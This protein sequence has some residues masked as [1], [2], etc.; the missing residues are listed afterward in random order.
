[1]IVTSISQLPD[2]L[3]GHITLDTE[4]KDPELKNIGPGWAF[5]D[6]G[7]ISGVSIVADN[8]EGYI[9]VHQARGGN[10]EEKSQ[11][12]KWLEHQL[13]NESQ[14]KIFANNQYDQGWLRRQGI[15]VKGPVEDVQI[16]A[17]LLDEYR[18]SYALDNLGKDYFGEDEGKDYSG[19]LEEAERCGVKVTAK[20]NPKSL[21]GEIWKFHAE[22]AG[23]YALQDARLTRRLWDLFNPMIDEQELRGVYNLECSLFPVLLEMRWRGVRVDLDRVEELRKE[24]SDKE[25]EALLVIQRETGVD[26]DPWKADSVAQVLDHCKIPYPQTEK[27][28]KPSIKADYLESLEHPMAKAIVTVRKYNRARGVFLENF[29]LGHQREG[30]VHCQ[31]NQMKSDEGGTVGGRFSSSNFNLQQIPT[32]DKE[33]GPK[34]RE[35]FLAEEGEKFCSIDFSAQ[36][37]R[38]TAEYAL[39]AGVRG[40]REVAEKYVENPRTD[41]HQMVA[42]LCGIPRKHAKIINLG[43]AYGM[44]GAKLCH[45][46]GLPTEMK[47]IR[48]RLL[49]VAGPEGQALLDRYHERAPFLRE[50]SRECQRAAKDRG[51]IRTILGRRCRFPMKNGERWFTHKAL[52]RLIQGSAADQTKKAMVDLWN[53]GCIPLATVHDELLFSVKNEEEAHRYRVIMETAIETTVPFVSDV[54]IGDNWGQ[55][56]E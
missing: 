18:F 50:L 26:M 21:G 22:V 5:K 12:W 3:Q 43:L 4:T 37:P 10:I 13:S 38:I 32:R 31:F 56:S 53:V 8:F 1:M 47:M 2:K 35:C 16:M 17:P 45:S 34:I 19:F 24:F 9:G 44:G 55:C 30:R 28:G 40:G 42:D 25:K 15:L 46:L 20:T 41:Y 36:E 6:S 33:I 49:E 23:N 39:R 52:N 7:F 11:F 48:G 54:A 27:T 14:L 51:F 29:I